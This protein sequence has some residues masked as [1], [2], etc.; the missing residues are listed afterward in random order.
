[1]D[2]VYFL[3]IGLAA[4]WI[5]GQLMHRDD[6]GWAGNLII[7][8]IGAVVG[9]FLL[10]LIGLATVSLLGSLVTAT[11]GAVVLLW[12]FNKYGRGKIRF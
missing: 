5:A 11:V 3:L 1:M 7:G 6:L 4:G 12:L 9:G 10:H 2:I 8:C